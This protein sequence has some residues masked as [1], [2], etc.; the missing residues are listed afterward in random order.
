MYFY[1][2][3]FFTN[4][5]LY[6]LFIALITKYFYIYSCNCKECL[7]IVWSSNTTVYFLNFVITEKNILFIIK[8]L[9][10]IKLIKVIF[11]YG[12]KISRMYRYYDVMHFW[13]FLFP[14]TTIIFVWL[15]VMFFVIII[16]FTFFIVIY[17]YF[18]FRKRCNMCRV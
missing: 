15:N 9:I 14:K 6:R 2:K 11:F 7:Y 16:V 18:L 5:L 13:Y 4:I 3:Y 12:D 17:V 10:I 1:R 8:K